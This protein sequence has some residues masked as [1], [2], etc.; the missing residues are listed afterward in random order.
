LLVKYEFSNFIYF[1]AYTVSG[2]RP[3]SPKFPHM[4][5]VRKALVNSGAFCVFSRNHQI[6]VNST[7]TYLK[8]YPFFFFMIFCV[9]EAV[10]DLIIILTQSLRERLRSNI[11]TDNFEKKA[12]YTK[13]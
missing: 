7:L 5:L 3:K 4:S 2:L 10:W 12:G 8:Y 11:I 6:L 9:L 13:P 1:Q